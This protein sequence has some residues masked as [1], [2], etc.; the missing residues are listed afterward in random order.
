MKMTVP[1]GHLS[2]LHEHTERK[3]EEEAALISIKCFV[4]D[5]CFGECCSPFSITNLYLN[6][7]AIRR[8]LFF[9]ECK[10]NV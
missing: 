10:I 2:N 9:K 7:V 1:P 3:A 5:S 4:Y 8:V 6:I